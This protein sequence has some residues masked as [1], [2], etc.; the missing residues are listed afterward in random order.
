M[1]I[2]PPMVVPKPVQPAINRTRFRLQS[3][4]YVATH[5]DKSLIVLHH[6]VGGDAESTYRWWDKQDPRRVGTAFLIDRDGTIYEV[7]PPTMWAWHLGVKDD[8]IE[9]RSIGIE[10]CSWGGL[11]NKGGTLYALD[12]KKALGSVQRLIDTGRV[13]HFPDGWRGYQYFERYGHEQIAQS[14]LLVLWLCHRYRIAPIMSRPWLG[15]ARLSE[16]AFEGIT[17]HALLRRDKSDLHPGYP[18]TR[19][20]SALKTLHKEQR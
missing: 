3:G 8:D 19:L 2:L 1:A 17:H 18:Y 10:L 9:R 6:T 5:R 13:E 4:Q 11:I 12:G 16:I 15:D 14:I 20:Q 7:F